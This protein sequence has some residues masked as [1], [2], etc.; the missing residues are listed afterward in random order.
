MKRK[1]NIHFKSFAGVLVLL[2][3]VLPAFAQHAYFA[4]SGE[5]EF[6]KRV[7]MFAKLKSRASD[8]NIFSKKIYEDYLKN[9][10]QFINSKSL[11]RFSE[12][13]SFY[14]FISAD[15]VKNSFAEDPWLMAKNQVYRNL[16]TDSLVS[17]KN[18]YQETYVVQDKSPKILWK[19]T[20]ETR[21]IAG[22]MCRRANGLIH[23]SIYVV[24]FYTEEIIPSVGPESFYGL[25]GAI[26]GVA[27]PHENV[28]W[29]AT[30][31]TIKNTPVQ[32][33][34]LPRRAKQLSFSS[35]IETLQSSLK[36]YG[37]WGV[38]LIKAFSI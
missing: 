3:F 36:N 11:L 35:F 27:L 38:S 20:T 32:K 24:A 37:E 15:E 6:E 29:F 34:T 33:P 23:D 10:P 18:V 8:D 30:K 9:S 31:V 26:L 14:D 17:V 7:N 19:I 12:G 28:T 25:P 13:A 5:I 1:L 16:T 2:A 21:E 4:Q 22:Y